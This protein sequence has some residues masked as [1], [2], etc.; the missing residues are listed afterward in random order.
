MKAFCSGSTV[1]FLIKRIICFLLLLASP[2]SVSFYFNKSISTKMF[3]AILPLPIPGT[4]GR[5]PGDAAL[6]SA[7]SRWD[8]P[9]CIWTVKGPTSSSATPQRPAHWARGP[10]LPWFPCRQLQ[11]RP[12]SHLPSVH[13][14]GAEHSPFPLPATEKH[15][16]IPTV[17]RWITLAAALLCASYKNPSCYCALAFFHLFSFFFFF[18]H[19][20]LALG[21][22][23]WISLNLRLYYIREK[24]SQWNIWTWL[25]CQN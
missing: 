7:W 22:H 12:S 25:S 4:K 9:N 11:I 20:K 3:P 5:F 14:R 8:A 10:A 17:R 2:L 24:A 18:S 13:I 1:I 19:R 23:E 21:E 16:P 6:L 15:A